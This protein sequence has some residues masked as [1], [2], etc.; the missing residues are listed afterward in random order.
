MEGRTPRRE[1][2]SGNEGVG[3]SLNSAFVFLSNFFCI[4][5][6]FWK[7]AIQFFQGCK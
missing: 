6:F 7:K 1:V 5:F 3:V 2:E 4:T